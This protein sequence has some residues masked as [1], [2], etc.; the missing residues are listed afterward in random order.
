M[1]NELAELAAAFVSCSLCE[2]MGNI[3]RGNLYVS[4]LDQRE[5]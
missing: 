2:I 1:K 3:D 5:T 4:L